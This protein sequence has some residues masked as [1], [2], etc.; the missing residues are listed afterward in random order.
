MKKLLIFSLLF[1]GFNIIAPASDKPNILYLYV[2]DMGWGSIGPNGQAER[3]AQGK[4]YVMTPTLD[5]LAAEGINFRRAYGCTVCS[6]ARSSQQTGFHQG[7]TFADRND[8]DNFKKAIRTDDIS[9][10][11]KLLKAGYTTGY[12]GK[13]G[14]GGSKD[15][16]NPTLDNIQTLP[17]S[18]GY[19][20]VVAE[21]HHVRAHTFFQ[22]TLWTAPAPS[23]TKGGLV[24]KPNT[25]APFMN[26]KAY[27]NYPS[28]QNHSDYPKTAY[29][30]D[31]YATAALDFIRQQAMNYN[32]TGKPFFGLFAAQIPHA[33][34]DEVS[35][36]PE[37][38]NQY[39]DKSYFKSLNKQSQ[40]W[41]AM[42]TRID[43]HFGNLLDA[44]EDPN[45][46]GDKSDSVAANTLIVFQS[47]N[48]G[49]G[50]ACRSELDSNGGLSGSKGSIQEGGIRVPTIMRWPAKIN[51]NSKLKSGTD[52]D[53]VVD[54]TDLLPTFCELAGVEAPV[55]INGVSLAPVLSGKGEQRVRDFIIHEAGNFASIIKGDYKLVR[56][57][58]GKA[59]K[60]KA[61]KKKNSSGNP[62]LYNLKSDPAEKVNIAS[63]NPE[64]VK[65]LNELLTAEMV[66]EPAGFANTYHKWLGGKS[67]SLS[68]GGNWSEYVY[69]N[70]GVKYISEKGSPKPFWI[71]QIA[72]GKAATADSNVEFLGLEIGGGNTRQSVTVNK[73]VT[74]TGRNEI[75]VSGKG[76]LVLNGGV[77]STLRWVE[78]GSEGTLSGNGKISGNLYS[79]GTIVTDGKTPLV[80]EQNAHLSGELKVVSS[81]VL[82]DQFTVLKAS[83]VKGKFK[84]TEFKHAGKSYKLVYT[85]NSVELKLVK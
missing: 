81:S 8:P 29:C 63:K 3:K 26:N 51:Q 78:I 54:C 64:I 50:G 60:G 83:S 4:P 76:S 25:M 12:W 46:D 47:D 56:S 43:A 67:N 14:Y 31:V 24:L 80:I 55:G 62:A 20:Y 6:P 22:P 68:S 82:P 59:G 5:R 65:E 85:E 58:A 36:L 9:I 49:P 17:T 66:D 33:P 72:N 41:C 77:L 34:F 1:V 79:M 28:F 11:D 52:S 84:N 35:K 19:Q 10:G 13:W 44:L 74:L 73:G 38:D 23:G 42:V 69:E 48:G 15:Q 71:A 37:W 39:R 16:N 32:K 18:H 61:T 40:Q 45:G 75:R 2:D 7:Y 70:A 30:D 57:R 21:L 53:L 27:P